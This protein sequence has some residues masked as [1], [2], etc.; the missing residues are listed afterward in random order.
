M[1]PI[2][3]LEDQL[4]DDPTISDLIKHNKKIKTRFGALLPFGGGGPGSKPAPEEKDEDDAHN[5][6]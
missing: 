1:W 4:E 2:V 5:G 3:P 6:G